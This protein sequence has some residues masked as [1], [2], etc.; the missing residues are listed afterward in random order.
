MSGEM[1][2]WDAQV[3]EMLKG[4]RKPEWGA[5]VSASL[6]YLRSMKY[7]ST[8]IGISCTFAIT[9]KGETALKEFRKTNPRK[10]S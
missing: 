4:D 2:E 1:L 5:A 6:E 10:D 8:R 3:L 7:V 9:P